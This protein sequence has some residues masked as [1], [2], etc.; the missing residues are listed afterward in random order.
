MSTIA[1]PQE[2]EK[3]YYSTDI[4]RESVLQNTVKPGEEIFGFFKRP[5][6]PLFDPE[7]I[8]IKTIHDYIHDGVKAIHKPYLEFGGEVNVS[9]I[10][11]LT[12]LAARQEI[13]LL[14]SIRAI[15]KSETAFEHVSKQEFSQAM[16]AAIQQPE[17]A[18]YYAFNAIGRKYADSQKNAPLTFLET[19]VTGA[20]LADILIITGRSGFLLSGEEFRT[21]VFKADPFTVDEIKAMPYLMGV[22]HDLYATADVDYSAHLK[23][24]ARKL[25]SAGFK[26]EANL[27]IDVDVE[28]RL[29]AAK[30][31]RRV[32]D[33]ESDG[34]GF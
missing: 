15:L 27:M 2:Q 34:P 12:D 9:L 13:T 23:S 8:K 11:T 24:T 6:H 22:V 26:T 14:G 32:V 4:Y 30:P 3:P 10:E 31:T 16:I 20:R 28:K 7:S 33:H 21:G 19:D 17:C 29:E 1:P 25:V 5:V 18:G